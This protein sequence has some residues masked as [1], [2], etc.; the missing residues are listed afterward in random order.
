MLTVITGT[1]ETLVAGLQDQPS[2]LKTA[3][4]IDQAAE[5]C[6]E[7]IQHLLAFARKQP[8]QPRNVDINATI[9]DIA[10]LLRPTLGEQIEIE[11]VLAQEVTTSHIDRSQ[12]ANSILNMAINARDAMPNGGKLLLETRNIVLDEAYAKDNPEVRPG[13]YVMLA[14]SDTG[15]GMA[16]GV[17]DKAF[18]PPRKSARVLGSASPWSM[19]SSNSRADIS[20][21]TARKATAPPSGCICRL[22]AG[23]PGSPFQRPRRYPT[24]P[25]PSSWWRTMRWCGTS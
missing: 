13:S 2:L 8:L 15:T 5:R 6:T 12:L 18:E 1:T 19:A 20:G 3:T 21:S 14:V 11:T 10:K 16:A 22:P 4:L 24:A 7:L 9:S 25:R 17:R 23:A